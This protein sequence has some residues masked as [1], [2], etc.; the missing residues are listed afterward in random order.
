MELANY[1][2][3]EQYKQVLDGE[4][5]RTA[6]GFVRIGYL[7]KVARDTNIL[8]ES[9]Y[10]SV[11]EFAQ[12]EYNLDKT[13][14]SRFISINDR[15]AEGGYSD[16]L[17]PDYQGY[18][19]AKLTIMLQIPE[20]IAEN[21]SANLSKQDIQAIKEEVDEEKKV[22]DLEILMEPKQTNLEDLNPLEK[23][24]YL[25]LKEEWKLY[26]KIWAQY[27]KSLDE[28]SIRSIL[29]PSGEKVYSV[30]I[31]GAG[32]TM[33]I[34]DDTKD[35]IQ[36]VSVRSGEKDGFTWEDLADAVH[37][38]VDIEESDTAK[39][40]WEILYGEKWP[41]EEKRVAPVQQ[42][43]SEKPEKKAEPK[44]KSKVRKAKTPGKPKMTSTEAVSKRDEKEAEAAAVEEQ[45][46]GQM[47]VEDYPEL[48]PEVA[49]EEVKEEHGEFDGVEG[50]KH[51]AGLSD[52]GGADG[53]A[54]E[55]GADQDAAGDAVSGD[56]EGDGV[57][58]G[59]GREGNLASL[60]NAELER[61]LEDIKEE[62]TDALNYLE[63]HF[64][65]HYPQ[66]ATMEQLQDMHTLAIKLA[67]GFEKLMIWKKEWN[68]RPDDAKD[69]ADDEE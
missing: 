48:L 50:G 1:Q 41:G 66:Y 45:L 3:Y 60:T 53:N 49:Y 59:G 13:Q 56:D 7:L 19:Y 9:G 26:E 55:S 63:R 27:Q 46:P 34:M 2:S 67:A 21:L 8:A 37:Q 43:T 38:M 61:Y 14:V 65:R 18:G 69:E 62:M 10:K 22:S 17:L 29:A 20:E 6:E 5:Q 58:E 36:L 32:R 35:E 15:F 24:L 25:L 57:A 16:H 44:K 39:E 31:P 30:R 42:V 47:T 51:D 33:M 54:G 11:A 68:S 4:L 52:G 40:S 64:P 12:A 28:Y 23:V